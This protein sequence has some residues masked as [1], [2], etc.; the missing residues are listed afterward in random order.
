MRIPGFNHAID[1]DRVSDLASDAEW[2]FHRDP[3]ERNL[4]TLHGCQF[5]VGYLEAA[6]FST[7]A[8]RHEDDDTIDRVDGARWTR[9]TLRAMS[10]DCR[11][12][13]G[14]F[15]PED[16]DSMLSEVSAEHAGQLLWYTAQGHGVGFWDGSI[17]DRALADRLT[18]AAK[19][20]NRDLYVGL[21]GAVHT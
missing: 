18:K 4:D 14:M 20:Y 16:R 11:G 2:A 5:V 3:T 10:G 12:F 7:L 8:D 17:G 13:L 21:R 19:L 15:T 6:S 1:V 9:A